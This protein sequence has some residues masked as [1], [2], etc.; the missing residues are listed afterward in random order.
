MH[1]AVTNG[2]TKLA[3]AA[4]RGTLTL[5]VLSTLLLISIRPAQAQTESVLYNFCSQPNCSDGGDPMSGL[6]SDGAGNFYGTTPA[7]GVN[8]GTV[9][10]NVYELSPNGSGGWN[11]T[12]L[13][14]FTG[15][16]DGDSPSGPVIFDSLGNLY[17][18]TLG[19][20]ANGYGV[21]F[22]L[23]S[24]GASWTETVL[25]SPTKREVGVHPQTG[26]IMDPAGNLYGATLHNVF[27]LSL[28]GGVWT[29]R[30]IYPTGISDSIAGGLAMD[31]VGNIF[32]NSESKVFKLS[33]NGT[34][35]WRASVLHKFAGY[36]IDGGFAQGT[37]VLDQAGNIYGTTSGG[38]NLGDGTVYEISAKKHG[39]RT[40]QILH[41]F[42]GG[43]DGYIP[44]S[45]LALDAAG[46]L[47][48]TTT[49]GGVGKAGTVYKL[50]PIGGGNYQEQILWSFNRTDGNSPYGTPILDS[51]GNIYGTTWAGG[52]IENGCAGSGCGVVFE[53]TP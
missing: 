52:S 7:G 32:G 24:V 44:V 8:S 34:G 51:A 2:T 49:G 33:P 53:V 21:V 18:A 41:S 16:A 43:N 45:G 30:I 38:G 1:S 25:Y 31:A 47:Y 36:P 15:G 20:G 12:V 27:E 3:A 4:I 11:E 48:G 13:H 17:G 50:A 26:L 9:A 46:N 6:T 37:P 14:T 19:G 42:Q 35:G 39:T 10:G 22:K 40:Y 28:S 23:R 29:A 5:A